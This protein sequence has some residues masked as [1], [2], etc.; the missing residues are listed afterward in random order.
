MGYRSRRCIVHTSV[1]RYS[2]CSVNSRRQADLITVSA[3]A[4]GK[5]ATDEDVV[6]CVVEAVAGSDV[7]LDVV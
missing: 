4:N 7:E 5:T 1:N 3:K 2:T 6:G